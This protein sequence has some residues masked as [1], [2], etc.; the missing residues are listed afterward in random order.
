MTIPILQLYPGVKNKT[1]TK[2]RHEFRKIDSKVELGSKLDWKT[3]KGFQG[4]CFPFR[5]L[6]VNYNVL[7]YM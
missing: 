4:Y 2:L 7:G 5:V 1:K 6:L 3:V